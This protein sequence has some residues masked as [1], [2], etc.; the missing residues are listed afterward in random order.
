MR[1]TYIFR[2]IELILTCHLLI[3][4]APVDVEVLFSNQI[5]FGCRAASTELLALDF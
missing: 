2:L 5:S 3:K 4:T 1:N